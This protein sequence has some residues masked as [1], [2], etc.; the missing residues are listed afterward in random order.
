M[1]AIDKFENATETWQLQLED[2]METIINSP[3][4]AKY[5]NDQ[6]MNLD[7]AFLIGTGL[8][9]RPVYSHAIMS[10]S[11]FDSYGSGYFP[12]IG[13]ILYDYDTQSEEQQKV[14]LVTLKKHVDQLMVVILRAV[15]HL[16]EIYKL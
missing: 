13:D 5:I 3:F 15:D 14:S 8:P 10:P 12:G 16:K 1:E 6:M 2:N 4:M 7:K 11:K 9:G